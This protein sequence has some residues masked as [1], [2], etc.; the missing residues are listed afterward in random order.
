MLNFFSG[1][2]KFIGPIFAKMSD[3]IPEVEFVS[4]DVDEAEEVA[5]GE[6]TCASW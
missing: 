3:E 5:A 4:V 6:C 2:C 1:P